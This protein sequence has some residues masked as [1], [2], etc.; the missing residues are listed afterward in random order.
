MVG[1]SHF[2]HLAICNTQS[3]S[4]RLRLDEFHT[5]SCVWCPCLWPATSNMIEYP[6]NLGCTFTSSLSW[7]LY[8]NSDCATW[9]QTSKS[10][11]C[12]RLFHISKFVCQLEMW[13]WFPL[14]HSLCVLVCRKQSPEDF[15]SKLL[16]SLITAN[17]SVQT[18]Q[19]LMA[20]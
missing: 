13:T 10:L 3:S 18:D 11:P 12:G 5:W 20:Q 16:V 9:C 15:T 19:H 7:A 14:D 17:S 6:L 8:R 4:S 1:Q 2:S